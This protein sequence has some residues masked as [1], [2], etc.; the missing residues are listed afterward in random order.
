MRNTT[1]K[2]IFS[3]IEDIG[4]SGAYL[5]AIATEKI[6]CDPSSIVGSVG[7]IV[8][9]FGFVDT[10]N[11]LGIER[12][13]YKTGKYKAIMDPFIKKNEEED[14]IINN[15]LNYIHEDFVNNIIKSRNNKL[16]V[17]NINEI[18]TGKFWVGKEAIKFGLIDGFY[19]IY[20]L[21]FEILKTNIIVNY[22]KEKTLIE[23]ISKKINKIF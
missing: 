3:I 7:V 10:I 14:K 2:K 12:R 13:L 18:S 23:I 16:I 21:S 19:D 15:S 22:T 5:I 1:N 9:Y 8:N 17:N 6:Y 11:K 20:S 4:T